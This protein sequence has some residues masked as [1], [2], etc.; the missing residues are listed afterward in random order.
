[1]LNGTTKGEMPSTWLTASY[2]VGLLIDLLHEKPP[3]S[4]CV[5]TSGSVQLV[6]KQPGFRVSTRILGWLNSQAFSD[7][8]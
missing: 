8:T 6:K 4:G 5:K 3:Y 2:Q 1:M 7:F